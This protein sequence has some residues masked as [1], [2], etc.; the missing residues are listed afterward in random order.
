ML[1]ADA[2]GLKPGD[3]DL[4][5]VPGKGIGYPTPSPQTRT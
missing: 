2:G 3:R 1:G 4:G 5:D